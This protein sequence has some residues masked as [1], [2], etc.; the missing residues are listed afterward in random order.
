MHQSRAT[1]RLTV[2]LL[3]AQL[4]LPVLREPTPVNYG[5]KKE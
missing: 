1:I 4:T 2:P 3:S 5:F